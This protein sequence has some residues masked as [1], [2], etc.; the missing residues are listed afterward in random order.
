M[1]Q[2]QVTVRR[3]RAADLEA[4]E[5][6]VAGLSVET[7]TKRFFVP[8]SRL[9]RPHARLLLANDHRR[10]SFVAAV[11]GCV[12]AHGCWVAVTPEVAEMAL[13]VA[14]TAQRR[15]VGRRLVRALLRDMQDAGIRDMEM[16]VEPG[17]RT[18][19]DLIHRSW[20][21]STPRTEDGLLMFVTP[22]ATRAEESRAV[23]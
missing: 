21:D 6:F 2:T 22:V 15:G 20:P 9:P 23:A 7:S 4:F 10:G 5:A 3:T 12:V 13:V 18:V 16:V 19:V 17:N 1:R 14:D 8:T 11:G